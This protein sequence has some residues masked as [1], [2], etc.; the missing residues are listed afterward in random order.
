V[1]C[2]ELLGLLNDYV[3]GEL[4]VEVRQTFEVHFNGCE[5]CG[6]LVHSYSYTARVA[7]KLPQCGLPP[8]VEAR[9][10]AKLEAELGGKPA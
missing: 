4:V 10:R 9:L 6:P 3:G 2:E 8:A 5:K 7:R 1:T